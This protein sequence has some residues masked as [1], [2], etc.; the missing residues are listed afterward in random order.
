MKVTANPKFHL[1]SLPKNDSELRELMEYQ[2]QFSSRFN[3][4]EMGTSNKAFQSYR[5]WICYA[6][7]GMTSGGYQQLKSIWMKEREEAE[8]AQREIN[9]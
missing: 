2:N 1:S 6:F 3:C 7:L 8:H 4:R 5:D 9:L